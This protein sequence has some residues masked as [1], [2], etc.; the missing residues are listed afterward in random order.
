L[1]SRGPRRHTH[2]KNKKSTNQSGKK[3]DFRRNKKQHAKSR[4]IDDTNRSG[5]NGHHMLC[6]VLGALY[7]VNNLFQSP[8]NLTPCQSPS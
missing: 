4:I 7:F 1:T 3:H 2:P 5:L 8:L 6:F